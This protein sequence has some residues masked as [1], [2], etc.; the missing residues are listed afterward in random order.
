MRRSRWLLGFLFALLV[1][2]AVVGLVFFGM[3][4]LSEPAPGVTQGNFYRLQI[5]MNENEV[6]ARLG[7]PAETEE[8]K[9]RN[10]SKCWL[11]QEH[12][13][14]RILFGPN[15]VVLDGIFVRDGQQDGNLKERGVM[16][17]LFRWLRL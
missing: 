4:L 5:G 1:L 16:D 17:R 14:V 2:M 8:K 10:S 6:E 7:G 15:G 9:G 3:A 11:G 13:C 12:T